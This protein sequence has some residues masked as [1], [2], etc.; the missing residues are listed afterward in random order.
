MTMRPH[1][2]T[3]PQ[4]PQYLAVPPRTPAA[5]CRG[6]Y[7]TIYWVTTEA[8]QAVPVHC[9]VEGGV[10]PGSTSAPFGGIHYYAGRG[11]A[12][13]DNCPAVGTHQRQGGT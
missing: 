3:A 5:P 2:A 11:I 9:D 4:P 10:R 6:C 13:R 1:A 12:H 8:G 7:A